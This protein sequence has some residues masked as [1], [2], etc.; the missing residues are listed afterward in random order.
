MTMRV[1]L[2]GQIGRDAAIAHKLAE[3]NNCELYI[4]AEHDNPTLIE[5]AHATGGDFYRV[6]SIQ[7]GAT[8]AAIAETVKAELVWINQDEAL[9]RGVIGAI[10]KQIPDILSASPNQEASRIEWDK[11][12][13]REIIQEIDNGRYNP[14]YIS[15]SKPD[16]LDDATTFFRDMGKEVVVKPRGLTGGK[17]VK[18]MGPHLAD[19]DQVKAY[20]LAV[21]ADP[22]QG[23]VVLEEKLDGYEFTVQ[24]FTDGKTLILPPATFD[25]PYREDGDKGSGTGGMG[26]FTMNAGEQLPFLKQADYDEALD[27]MQ[28]VLEKLAERSRDYKG[29][30]YGSFFKTSVG[31]KV[32][33]FN[34]RIG[35]PEGINIMELLADD[36]ELLNILKRISTQELRQEDVRFRDLASAVI[37]LVSPD[38]TYNSGPVYPFE[39]DANMVAENDCRLYFAAA[40]Q[41][42]VNRYKTVGTSRTVALAARDKT[43]WEAREKIHRSIQT[44]IRGP[45]AF[46]SDVASKASIQR[47]RH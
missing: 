20:A 24:S 38:Y 35:D 15:L 21:L 7:D 12:Y 34:A 9:A 30:L 46:R 29:V 17:G 14:L 16:T 23:G 10:T 39:I 6:D 26:C 36:V 18:V 44:A 5:A 1:F 40:E 13:S 43:P 2:A 3:Q 32:V 41:T 4:T 37:Y 8:L 33:E 31:L 27:V 45:L 25:Y 47:M 42:G 28:Q 19:Y 22:R 11:F